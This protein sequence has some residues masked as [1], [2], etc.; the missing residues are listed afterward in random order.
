LATAFAEDQVDIDFSYASHLAPDLV[1]QSLFNLDISSLDTDRCHGS[2]YVIL[3]FF[4]TEDAFTNLT[5]IPP[6][7]M[8]VN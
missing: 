1:E 4:G 6:L 2:W 3:I 7:Q 8:V 5:L